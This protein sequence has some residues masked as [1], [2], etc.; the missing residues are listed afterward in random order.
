MGR[1]TIFGSSVALVAA[2]TVGLTSACAHTSP[3]AARRATLFIGGDVH[4]GTGGRGALAGIAAIVRG[5]PGV[6]NLEG[7]IGDGA[8]GGD[9]PRLTQAPGALAELAAAG[10]RVAGIAN[11][12][13]GDAGPGGA[14]A[15]ARALAAVGVSAAGAP[16]GPAI[17]VFGGLRVVVTAHDLAGGVPADLGRELDQARRRGDVLVATFHVTGP[18]SYL[19]APELV[20]A[21]D[22]ALAAGAAVVAAHGTHALAR[23]ERRGRAVIGWGLGNL[24]FSCDCTDEENGALLEVALTP[25]GVAAA[26]VIPVDAGLAGAPARAAADP[27]F[28]FDLLGALGSSP[29]VRRGDRASF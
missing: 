17:V 22:V 29:L 6:V 19:P 14:A 12:H 20:R 26:T 11:N 18:P 23:V 13:A 24:A 3:A 8:S 28:T 1:S 4:L 10:I 9:P 16:A 27:G 25:D 5:V 7:P 15:T 2:L 21:V